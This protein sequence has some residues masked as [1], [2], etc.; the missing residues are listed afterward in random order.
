MSTILL[1]G[2]IAQSESDAGKPDFEV[3]A[4]LGG[5]PTEVCCEI[6]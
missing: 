6:A 3:M 2:R 4:A 5:Q 1:L